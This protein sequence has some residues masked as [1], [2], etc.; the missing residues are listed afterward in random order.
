MKKS[1][2]ENAIYNLLY[3][4][5]SVLFPLV[6]AGYISRILLAEGI[7]IVNYAQTIASYFVIFASLGIPTLGIREIARATYGKET[8][9][10]FTNL[11]IFNS[12]S[13]AIS[14]ILYYLIVLYTP[15]FTDKLLYLSM[16]S[17]I[18]LNIFN[19]D[20]FYQGKEEYRY[21]AIRS[22]I[23]K[24]LFTILLFLTIKKRSDYILYAWLYCGATAGNYLFNIIHLRKL[25]R[26]DFEKF[27]L[28]QYIKPIFIFFS[29]SIAVELYIQIDVTMLGLLDDKSYVGYYTNSTK[30]IRVIANSII[31]LGFVI[32]PRI[33]LHFQKKEFNDIKNI[34]TK[35]FQL[36][37]FIS[38]PLAV[39]TFLLSDH[40]IILL[41]GANFAPSILTLQ[42]L[43]SLIIIFSIAGGLSTPVLLSTNQEKKYFHS[44]I[45]G[46]IL[47]IILNFILIK[48]YKHNGAAIASI[49]TELLITI[50]Q[51][52]FLYK[53]LYMKTIC[54]YLLK[55]ILFSVLMG[56]GIIIT[57]S[58]II[59]TNNELLSV[60]TPI[61]VG[62]TIYLLLAFYSKDESFAFLIQKIFTLIKRSKHE[63]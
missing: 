25:V 13:S 57:S 9:I 24:L 27:N 35:V 37:F 34:S 16:G 63:K 62:L 47:N 51:I 56:I 41:F 3:K 40:I 11:F 28:R 22:F 14:A 46:C 6:S 29:A 31:A 7:G 60:F 18:I 12:I 33:S 49:S 5:L 15:L 21:I 55:I 2:A 19:V 50:I 38:C 10:V 23:V 52:I 30:L 26:L 45:I 36:L 44:T 4:L 58:Y 17:I 42:I 54:K 1:I 8:N 39:I 48:T 20:W 59:Y 61:S 43:S 32:I 53:Y